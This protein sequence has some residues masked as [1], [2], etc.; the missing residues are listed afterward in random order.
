MFILFFSDNKEVSVHLFIFNSDAVAKGPPRLTS[1]QDLGS[2]SPL[3]HYTYYL[4]KRAF[5]N[6]TH[7]IMITFICQ[8][9]YL[10]QIYLDTAEFV[11]IT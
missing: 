6:K 10:S 9:T 1:A 7:I 5:I 4:E 8:N 11:I 2:S 3:F